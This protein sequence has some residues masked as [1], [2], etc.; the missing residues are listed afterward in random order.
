MTKHTEN[1][2]IAAEGHTL[3]IETSGESSGTS[4]IIYTTAAVARASLSKLPH[5]G[6]SQHH[7]YGASSITVRT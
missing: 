4:P 7:S 2:Y 6:I 5:V 3:V 1:Q